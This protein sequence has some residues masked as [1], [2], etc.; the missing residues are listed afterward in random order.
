MP[1]G[2]QVFQLRIEL[3]EVTPVVWR[4]LLVPGGVRLAELHDIIQAAMG[5]GRTHTSTR[6]RS[7]T[8]VTA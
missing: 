1:T 6:S 2:Q 7:T 4:R 5:A 8:T 3:D